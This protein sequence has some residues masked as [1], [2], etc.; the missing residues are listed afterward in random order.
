MQEELTNFYLTQKEPNKSCLLALRE[1]IL[2]QD[3]N[4]TPAW[5]YG[6]PFFCYNGKMFCYLW[7]HK[8]KLQPYIGFVEGKHLHH[9]DLL[10]EKRSRMKTILFDPNADLPIDT[11]TGLVN[12]AIELYQNGT[13]KIKR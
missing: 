8:K 1:M 10:M 11:I 9:P 12:Q 7:V 6:M 3:A 4:I 5:K 13:V 2:S